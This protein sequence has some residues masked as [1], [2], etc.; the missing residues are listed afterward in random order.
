MRR[1]GERT[2]MQSQKRKERGR[3]IQREGERESREMREER[4]SEKRE[5]SGEGKYPV[6]A[7]VP[8]L[9]ALEGP[10]SLSLSLSATPRS[11]KG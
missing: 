8:L 10:V 4:G 5:G 1:G 2:E 9:L 6:A 7:C 3:K 11:A